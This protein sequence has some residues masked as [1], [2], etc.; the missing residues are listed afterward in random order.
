MRTYFEKMADLGKA[1]TEKQIK[2]TEE[3]VKQI[4]EVESEVA[5]AVEKVKKAGIPAADINKRGELTV[6]QRLEYL[7]DPGT[8]CPLHTLY[9]PMEEESGTTGVVDGLGRISGKWAVV[10][11]FDNKVMAGA[12]IA[13]QAENILRVTDMAKRLHVPLVWLVN[14]SGVKL[15]E[16]EKVY[17]NRRGNGTTFY[18]HAELE[19]LGIPVLAGI[20]GTNPAGGGYQGI[21]PTILL[22]HK[23]CNIAVGGGGIVSG[24]SPKGFFDEQGAELIIDATKKFKAVPPGRVQI[25]YDSTGFFKAVFETEEGVLDGLK[26]WMKYL[27]SYHPKFFRVADPKEP[28]FSPEEVNRLVPFNQKMAYSL[29][30]VLARLTDNS[31]HMEFRPG[32][33]PEV[34]TG[35]AKIDGFLVGIIGNRQ[36]FLPKG[37]PEYAPYPGVG[38]KFYRQGLIKMNEFVTQCGRDRVPIIWFQDTT[39]IDVGDIAE[40]AELLG[41]GQSLIYSIEQTDLPMMCVVLRKGTAAAHYIMGGPQANNNNVFTLGTPTTEI[42]VMH[43]ETAAVASFARRLVKEKEAGR[44][45]KPTIEKMNI[46]AQEYHDKSRPVYCAKTGFVDEVVSFPDIRKYLV[47]FAD[48]VYQNPRSI[49]PQNHMMLPRLIRG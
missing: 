25:H 29:E 18:R 27:P 19:K 11:G 46:L 36:G 3:N 8:W 31:E 28:K 32:Y 37:Y 40:K 38:G 21:S 14:C 42:Y 22:A 6:Y 48:S 44:P 47:A 24:M 16:Q 13:G 7:L 33:G 26:E 1:L 39:G 2:T 5:M 43:G 41:L 20:Y 35:L 9:D 17:A 30:E 49:C 34:Y 15:P 12:W 4:K 23:N 10:I 45:L